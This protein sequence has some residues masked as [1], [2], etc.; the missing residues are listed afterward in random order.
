ML[1]RGYVSTHIPIIALVDTVLNRFGLPIGA[2]SA[3][4]FSHLRCDFAEVEVLQV[5]TCDDAKLEVSLKMENWVSV[6]GQLLQ[7]SGIL[8]APDVVKL[9]DSI[10]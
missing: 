5:W 2:F 3:T 7:L 6:E 9:F 8:E 4:G 10:V 1:V